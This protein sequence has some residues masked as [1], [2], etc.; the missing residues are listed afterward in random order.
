MLLIFFQILNHF[1]VFVVILSEGR[2][3]YQDT[4]TFVEVP[5]CCCFKRILR[6]L[7][8]RY[9]VLQAASKVKVCVCVCVHFKKLLDIQSN[10]DENIIA[11]VPTLPP[12]ICYDDP[13]T[14]EELEAALSQL[15]TRKAGGLSGI[16]PELIL[17]GGSVL[18]DRLLALMRR[19]WDEH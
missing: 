15:K 16:V 18:E 12:L 6:T 2:V 17:F 5:T 14:S 1:S 9:S 19:I 7:L 8:S 3:I 10:Y 13:P 11:A 4:I